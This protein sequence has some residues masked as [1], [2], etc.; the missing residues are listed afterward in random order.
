MKLT[1]LNIWLEDLRNLIIDLNISL[2]NAK[3]L[4]KE[5]GTPTEQKI[6]EHGFFKHH[7]Y[8]LKFIMII[9]LCK[10]FD[11][12]SNQKINVH[13]LFNRLRNE[14]YDKELT[15]KLISNSDSYNGIKD[16]KEMIAVVNSLQ[17]KILLKNEFIESLVFLRNKVYA[18]K[19]KTDSYASLKWTD[20]EELIKL[21]SEIYNKI[22]GGIYNSHMYFEW[23]GDWNVKDIIQNLA[24]FRN[25]KLGNE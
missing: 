15:E 22:Y 9:Q 11:N 13:K 7:I 1:E 18:H 24:W 20:L 2:N 12:N 3:Y 8:Q 4:I 14:G 21:S 16:K 19:D 17:D 5:K 23:T 10:I 6:K 25:L